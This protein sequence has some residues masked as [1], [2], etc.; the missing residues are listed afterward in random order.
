MN[1]RDMVTGA[2]RYTSD[3]VR[4]G[5]LHGRVLRPT[6]FHA[7]LASF[8]AKAAGEIEDAV[9]V[10]D[11]DFVGAVAPDELT[12]SQAIS[13]IKT[14]WSADPQPSSTVLFEYL[15]KGA[16]QSAQADFEADH[17]L[18]ATYTVAYI[19]HVPLEPRAAVA[20]W[21]DG[22]LTVWT[23]TQRPFGVKA[24]L[25]EAFKIPED[26]RTRDRSGHRLGLRRQAHR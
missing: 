14:E 20:E 21:N 15:R 3:L 19:A 7:K 5:M 2:H 12:L 9:I 6:A 16:T 17:K 22:K 4:P 8:D 26:T 18:D 13:A 24:E 11:G 25:A 23:G 1:A 10:R